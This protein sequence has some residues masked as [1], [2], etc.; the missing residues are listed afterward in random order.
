MRVYIVYDRSGKITGLSTHPDGAPQPIMRLETGER[1]GFVDVPQVQAD[2]SEEDRFAQLQDLISNYRVQVEAEPTE[3]H[4]A[5]A[6]ES[7]Y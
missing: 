2:A 5:P 6:S 1:D 7:T 3:L 4:L